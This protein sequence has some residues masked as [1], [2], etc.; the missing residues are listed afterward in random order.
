MTVNV[1]DNANEMAAAL[2][3]TDQYNALKGAFTKMKADPIAYGLFQQMQKL[4]GELEQK[5]MAGT[6]IG[7]DDIQSM[8]DLSDKL[9]KI[10][11]MTEL[12]NSER[13]MNQLMD[14]MNQ[15]VSKPITDLYHD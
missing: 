12:M 3:Q 6:Q 13:A 14:E 7:D 8:R 11:V 5:Q 10:D 1:Y 9:M 4:Q 15:I 2:R